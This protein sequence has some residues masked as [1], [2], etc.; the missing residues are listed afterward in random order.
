MSTAVAVPSPG[1]I[2]PTVDVEPPALSRDEAHDRYR[3]TGRRS[4]HVYRQSSLAVDFRT[5]EQ[6]PQFG[7]QATPTAWLPDPQVWSRQLLSLML[8]CVTGSRPPR[9]L[10]RWFTAECHVRL[11]RRHAAVH[12]RGHAAVQPA[13]V[14]RMRVCVVCEGVVELSAVAMLD[15]RARAVAVRL[16]A[17]DGR[18]L[19]T[20]FLIA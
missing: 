12:R 17:A 6:D 13:R 9:Q 3:Q 1:R 5:R 4:R 8:E 19:V 7:P 15:G 20:D 14:R 18:W 10:V 2:R 11:A 16:N